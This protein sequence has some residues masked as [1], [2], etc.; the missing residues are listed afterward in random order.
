MAVREA[1]RASTRGCACCVRIYSCACACEECA[2]EACACEAY[3]R[4][5]PHVQAQACKR[6]HKP[7]SARANLY[8]Y[9][10]ALACGGAH[11]NAFQRALAPAPAST[12]TRLRPS[13]LACECACERACESACAR[14][15]NT[16]SPV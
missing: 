11:I 1:V 2:C 7:P 16:Q 14:V 9:A 4:A 5:S 8:L 10:C 12:R 13:A 15:I 3:E 6:T